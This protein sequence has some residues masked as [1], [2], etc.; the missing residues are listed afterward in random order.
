MGIKDV[1]EKLTAER[2][3][4]QRAAEKRESKS[5]RAQEASDRKKVR[6]CASLLAKTGALKAFH[7]LNSSVF[8][9]Q[10]EIVTQKG[11]EEREIETGDFKSDITTWHHNFALAQISWPNQENPEYPHTII[12]EVYAFD[13]SLS[14]YVWDRRDTG[15]NTDGIIRIENNR[16][17]QKYTVH[18]IAEVYLRHSLL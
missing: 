8:G 12:A 10:A 17:L 6:R 14:F 5:F 1:I 16:N 11:T 13:S 2:A 15:G 18:A 9:G 3:A 4:A 7:D